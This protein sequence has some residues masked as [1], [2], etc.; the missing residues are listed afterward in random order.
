[1]TGP[2]AN[3]SGDV[4]LNDGKLD[5]QI[6]CRE[7]QRQF[8]FNDVL[9]EERVIAEAPVSSPNR[10]DLGIEDTHESLTFDERVLSRRPRE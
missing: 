4:L 8:G 5:P 1:M 7:R 3:R 2:E 10:F 6:E 9:H